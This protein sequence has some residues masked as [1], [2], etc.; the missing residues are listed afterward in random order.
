MSKISAV[1]L[2][3]AFLALIAPGMAPRKPRRPVTRSGKRSRG[4]FPSLKATQVRYES[5]LELQ[6]WRVLEAGGEVTRFGSHPA[7]LR[8]DVGYESEG[9]RYTPDFF[10][11]TPMRETIVGEVKPDSKFLKADTRNRMRDV[12]RA[13]EREGTQF[14]ILLESDL[15]C[16][17]CF[18]DEL[19]IL[20]RDRPWRKNWIVCQDSPGH[21]RYDVDDASFDM[22]AWERA[23][24][25][26]NALLARVMDRDFK[27]TVDQAQAWVNV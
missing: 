22:V 4:N 21:E 3:P 26:C 16:A 17:P 8:I 10:F 14:V 27:A 20:L 7:S 15:Q 19:E 13:F 18:P 23:A 6:A 1:S 12:W 11:V 5:Q 24:G 2:D 9:F 25:E